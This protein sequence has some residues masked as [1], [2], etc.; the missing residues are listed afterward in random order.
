MDAAGIVA[1]PDGGYVYISN[2]E[3]DRGGV[4]GLYFNESGEIIDYKALL[5]GKKVY[6]ADRK[7][8]FLKRF[9][10]FVQAL[11]RSCSELFQRT[12]GTVWNCGGGV[13]PWNTWVSCEEHGK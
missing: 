6:Y 8:S 5:R 3:A 2:S 12:P 13:T 10:V 1:L 11:T 7:T 4:Y 9:A